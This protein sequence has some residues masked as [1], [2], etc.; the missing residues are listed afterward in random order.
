[1]IFSFTKSA[2]PILKAGKNLYG[3]LGDLGTSVISDSMNTTA[4]AIKIARE[5]GFKKAWD[6]VYHI[7]SIDDKGKEISNLNYGAIAE[8]AATGWI[9]ASTIGRVATGGGLYRDADGN[10]DIIGIPFI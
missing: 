8:T 1:M 6:D 2:E 9:G 4:D 5:N 3:Q 7:K 10:T